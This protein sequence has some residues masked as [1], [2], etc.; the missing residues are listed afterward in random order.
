MCRHEIRFYDTDYPAEDIGAWFAEGLAAGDTCL[1]LLT[2][3]HQRAV[4]EGLRK[5]GVEIGAAAYVT[6]DSAQLISLSSVDGRLD[7]DAAAGFLTPLMQAPVRGS[8][9]LRA[10]GDMAPTLHRMGRTDDAVAFENLVHQVAT[11]HGA[12][13]VCA[14][15][16]RTAG[17]IDAMLRL[18][19]THDAIRFPQSPWI[20]H[21]T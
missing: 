9:R 21:L 17:T 12:T 11:Q 1:A 6:V 3:E 16:I 7:I 15:P 20:H 2:S 14:Y 18:S 13:V 10:V 4:E 5:R 19:A 8:G